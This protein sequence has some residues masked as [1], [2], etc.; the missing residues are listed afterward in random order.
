MCPSRSIGK[1]IVILRAKA[2]DLKISKRTSRFC[3]Q[4]ENPGHKVGMGD[5]K[6]SSYP[7]LLDVWARRGGGPWI[8]SAASPLRQEEERAGFS[9]WRSSLD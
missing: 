1:V 3:G 2:T 4:L 9:R 5:R 7:L 6:G 8:P